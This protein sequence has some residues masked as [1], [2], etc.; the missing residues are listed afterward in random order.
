MPTGQRVI[1]PA[2]RCEIEALIVEHSWMLDNHESGQLGELYVES[3]KMTG[4][5]GD[6]IGRAAISEYGRS[7]AKMTSRFAR[8]VNSNIR[9][10]SIGPDRISSLS[11][12]LLLRHDGEGLGPADPI[13]LADAEDIFVLDTDGR[14]RFEHRNLVLRFE[15]EAHRS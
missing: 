5:G 1:N 9:L 8:H 4:I 7:R 3:G 12:I 6:R 2:I 14:W 13:A 15:S 11:S 10:V